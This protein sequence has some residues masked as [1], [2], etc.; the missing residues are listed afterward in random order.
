MFEY[1][2]NSEYYSV[3]LKEVKGR[4]KSSQTLCVNHGKYDFIKVRQDLANIHLGVV[5]CK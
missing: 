3:S 2:G 4:E 5:T 1:F